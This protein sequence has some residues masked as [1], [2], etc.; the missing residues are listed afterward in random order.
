[1]YPRART[2]LLFLLMTLILLGIGYAVGFT[3]GSWPIGLIAMLSV[4][5]VIGI[6][7]YF[8]SKSA[9]LRANRARIVTADE[10]PRLHAIVSRLALKAELPMPEIGVADTS[11][12]NAFATGRNPANAA[13]VA[14]R[15]LLQLLPDDELEAVFAHELSHVRNRDILVMSVVS[16]M[17]ATVSYTTRYAVWI[18]LMGGNNRGQAL[19]VSIALSIMAPVAALMIQLGVSRSREYL[20]DETAARMTNNPMALAR[21]LRSISTGVSSTREEFTAPSYANLMIANP[22][23]GRNR[24]LLSALFSTHPPIEER[25]RRLEA[26]AGYGAPGRRG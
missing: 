25:I 7:S 9:A 8:F 20:A 16:T 14:T 15:G 10:E 2:G 11:A 3:L 22:L 23:T 24:T 19:L 5:V 13:V 21:A 4:S 18:A 17:A 1:M 6:Y 12:P 26:M